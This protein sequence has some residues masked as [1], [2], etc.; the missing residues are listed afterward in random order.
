MIF[1]WGSNLKLWKFEQD[2]NDKMFFDLEGPCFKMGK[3]SNPN[4]ALDVI[5]RELSH[6]GC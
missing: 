6:S 5:V 3:N 1:F 2:L 4:P